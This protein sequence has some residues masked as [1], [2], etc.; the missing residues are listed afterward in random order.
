MQKGF[1]SKEDMYPIVE[2]FSSS[3]KT[4]KEYCKSLGLKYGTYKYWCRKYKA[5]NKRV[6]KKSK[7]STS[8]FIDLKVSVPSV[9]SNSL[10]IVYPNGV[11]LEFSAVLDDS[12]MEMLKKLVLCLD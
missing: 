1:R 2:G 11:R 7:S 8:G 12:G 9:V 10:E 3:G 6:V 5:E 4:H